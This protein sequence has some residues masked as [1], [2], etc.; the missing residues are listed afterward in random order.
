MEFYSYTTPCSCAK[1]VRLGYW[2][3]TMIFRLTSVIG[4]NYQTGNWFL[5]GNTTYTSGLTNGN[6]DY[7]FKTGLFDFNTG[8]HTAPAWIL[9]MSA[10]Y[11]FYVNDGYTIEPSI[12]INN[13]PYHAHLIKGAFFSGASY[14]DRRNF[15]VKVAYHF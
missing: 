1:G 6:S 3:S 7:I 15:M 9:N 4:L 5:N 11:T 10:R 2:I 12:Y 8:A 13:V 14:E